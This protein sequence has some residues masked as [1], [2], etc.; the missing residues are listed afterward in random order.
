MGTVTPVVVP[1]EGYVR[2]EVDWSSHT[3]TR[4]CWIYRTV[5]GVRTM[6]REGSAARLSGGVAVA[7]DHEMPYDVPLTYS[8]VIALNRNGDF[9]DGVAEWL[10][11][12]NS[13][14]VGTVT[15]S[16]AYYVAG[17]GL[18]S[19]L[20]VPDGA[21]AT[22]QAVSEMIPAT[23]GTVYTVVGRIMLSDYWSGGVG[24]R[25]HFFNGTTLLSTVGAYNDLAPIP[26]TFGSYG[27]GATAPATTTH[28]RIMGGLAGTPPATLRAYLDEVYVTAT[29][30]S[31]TAA[32]VTVPS[33]GAGWWVDPLHPATKVKLRLDLEATTCAPPA[34]VGLLGVSSETHA[35]D[36][37]ALSINNS[38]TP[39]AAWQVRKAGQQSMQVFTVTL[40]DLAQVQALHSSGAPLLLQLPPLY[41]EPPAYQLHDTLEVG[42]VAADMRRTWRVCRSAFSKVLPPVGPPDGTWKARYMDL[43]KHSTFAAATAAGATWLDGLQGELTA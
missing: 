8:S 27:L 24:V 12:T 43:T 11:T 4:K 28:M 20:L 37:E 32:D 3:H 16:K 7:F 40:T 34:A 22:A 19:A 6:L 33:D 41:G 14:T 30:T 9:E 17:E 10:D 15:Q 21:S 25:V 38:A 23:A 31:V 2:V 39:L 5:A 36:A 13:G 18:A 42:R 1:G 35:A 29:G 26:G